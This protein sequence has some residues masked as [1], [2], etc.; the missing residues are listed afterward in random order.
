[1]VERRH[2]HVIEE[3]HVM[4]YLKGIVDYGLRYVLDCEII[5]QGYTDLDWANSVTY[6]KS[7][8]GCCLSLGS[9]MISRLNKK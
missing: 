1:M 3:M 8:S 7:T 2:V 6:Q 9:T 4:R 5:L